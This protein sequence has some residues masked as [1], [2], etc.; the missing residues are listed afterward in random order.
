MAYLALS[1]KTL[2]K[3]MT[4]EQ[5]F[6]NWYVE[7]IECKLTKYSKLNEEEKKIWMDSLEFRLYYLSMVAIEAWRNIIKAFGLVLK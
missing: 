3:T 5:H 6:E 7:H 2:I 1:A 4:I